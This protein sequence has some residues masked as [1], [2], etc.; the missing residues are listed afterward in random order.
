MTTA[1]A[2][3]GLGDA[4]VR[5]FRLHSELTN[6]RCEQLTV[7]SDACLPFWA[8]YAGWLRGERQVRVDAGPPM[9]MS[10]PDPTGEVVQWRSNGL[11]SAYTD[12]VIGHLSPTSL[13]YDDFASDVEPLR[14]G[15]PLL[16]VLAVLSAQRGTS[17]SYVGLARHAALGAPGRWR[18]WADPDAGLEFIKRWNEFHPALRL[19]SVC[20][21]ITRERMLLALPP[22]LL[23]TLSGCGQST[24]GWCGDCTKCFDTFYAAKAVGHERP[25]RLS[26]RIFEE[27]YLRHYRSWLASEFRSDPCNEQQFL[28][29]LQMTYGV[30]FD[31]TTD[32]KLVPVTPRLGVAEEQR[33]AE[34]A[35]SAV[36]V[37]VI[38]GGAIGIGRAYGEAFARAGY[39]VVLADVDRAVKYAAA[40]LPVVGEGVEHSGVV[41]D[42]SSEGDVAALASHV[43]ERYGRTDLLINNAAIMLRVDRPFKPFHETPW[44]EW[45]RIFDV[46]VGGMFLVT[47]ALLELLKSTKDSIVI[48]IGSDAVW[49]GYDGQLAYFASKG[50]IQPL[51]RSMAR[52]LGVYGIRVN[53]LAPGYT[54][55]EAVL[56]NEVM[57]DVRP[58]VQ[59]ACVIKRDQFPEDV[60]NAAVFLASDA[61]RCISGQVIVVNCGAIMP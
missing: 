53:C 5:Y 38:T 39:N 46:N 1:E 28:A 16:F 50:A 6:P 4:A 27:R 11:A 21:E 60:A 18:G 52:E 2:R 30:Q 48:N 31:R 14:E 24:T 23:H 58:L 55:S 49:K 26:E 37:A 45:R 56:E 10:F 51:T 42:V 36:K 35:T 34:K 59:S 17:C 13:R 44:E 15:A 22:G 7:P 43:Q 54:L 25:F 57:A 8:W 61:A 9:G 19:R 20:S 33:M 32:V 12:T 47:K 41:T 3:T 40:A 29:Y